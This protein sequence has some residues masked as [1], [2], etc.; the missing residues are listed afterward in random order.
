[1]KNFAHI[2]NREFLHHTLCPMGRKRKNGART[3]TGRLS[4]A[5]KNPEVRDCG[6]PEAQAK[7]QILVG[8]GADPNH[9]GSIIQILRQYGHIDQDQEAAAFRYANLRAA[10]HGT[11]WPSHVSGPEPSPIKLA[12]LT[13]EFDRMAKRLTLDQKSVITDVAAFNCHPCWFHGIRL[14]LK[15]LPEDIHEREL[16]ITGL[17]ALLGRQAKRAA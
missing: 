14:G 2:D 10:V 5:Y 3:K 4:R 6:T 15:L 7:R 11:P 16:L 13:D 9:S 12:K 1:V 8:D 17:D